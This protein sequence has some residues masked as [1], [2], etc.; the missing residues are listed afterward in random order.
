MTICNL[1]NPPPK[2]RKH[3]PFAS[4]PSLNPSA[5]PSLAVLLLCVIRHIVHSTHLMYVASVRQLQSHDTCTHIIKRCE[6]PNQLY[7]HFI[8]FIPFFHQKSLTVSP[9]MYFKKKKKKSLYTHY[10]NEHITSANRSTAYCFTL[11]RV[12]CKTS[13]AYLI[14][15]GYVGGYILSSSRAIAPVPMSRSHQPI[16]RVRQHPFHPF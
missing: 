5:L 9:R 7:V 6:L 16:P 13:S 12:H 10:P 3:C 15:C 4:S 14:L 1:V 8:D 11:A 2:T